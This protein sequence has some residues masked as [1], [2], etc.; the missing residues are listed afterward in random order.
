MR[1]LTTS[2]FGSYTS[3]ADAKADLKLVEASAPSTGKFS[4]DGVDG[5]KSRY[6]Y[7]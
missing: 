6:N 4:F 2:E 5:L 7:L 1:A 3:A